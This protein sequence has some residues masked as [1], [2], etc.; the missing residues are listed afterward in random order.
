[1]HL[2]L[3]D[4]FRAKWSADIHAEWIRNVIK[5]RPDLKR[6]Q[7]ERT[8]MLM[9][10]HVRD[11]LVTGYESLIETVS[12]P[13]K[14]DRHVLAAAIVSKA[15]KIV[16][17]NLKDFP[18]SSLKPYNIAVEHPDIFISDLLSRSPLKICHAVSR[19]RA[20][21][22]HPTKSI[23]EYLSTLEQQR[24]FATVT[25]LSEFREVI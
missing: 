11:C 4:L 17:F 5:V 14:D 15:D 8:R 1:M 16:T 7:L 6:E 3:T 25:K 24:L 9:D 13:D 22:K 20:S 19:H 18:S 23:N 21:L 12:L 2:A 10:A